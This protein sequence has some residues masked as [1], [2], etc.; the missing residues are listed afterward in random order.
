MK[1]VSKNLFKVK[2]KKVNK[3]SKKWNSY[4]IKNMLNEIITAKICNPISHTKNKN[5]AIP[6]CTCWNG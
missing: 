4:F 1:D 5:K 2:I 6:L 3:N